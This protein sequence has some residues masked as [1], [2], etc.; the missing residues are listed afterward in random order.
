LNGGIKANS[1]D[2]LA[3]KAGVPADAMKDTVAR[4]NQYVDA[5]KDP[6]FG[7]TD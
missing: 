5:G 4:Y 1:L 3:A 7:R 2:V 6:D